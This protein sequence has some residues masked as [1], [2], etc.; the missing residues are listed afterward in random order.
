MFTND[1]LTS[2]GSTAASPF[3]GQGAAAAGKTVTLES[4]QRAIDDAEAKIQGLD[5]MDRASL[6][7]GVLLEVKDV[8][9][10]GRRAWEDKLWDAKLTY[11]DRA[12]EFVAQARQV[13]SSAQNVRDSANGQKLKPDDPRVQDFIA[14]LRSMV[15]NALRAEAAFQAVMI[16]GWDLSK[17]AAPAAAGASSPQVSAPAK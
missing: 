17:K 13:L 7:H 10:P 11:V 2:G 1:D 6:V 9:F 12:K 16:E 14:Q 5:A 4:A 8:D 3:G 15:Q